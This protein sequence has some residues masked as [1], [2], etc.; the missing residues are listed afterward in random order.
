MYNKKYLAFVYFIQ[1]AVQYTAK[2]IAKSR[3]I[4]NRQEKSRLFSLEN[5]LSILVS[6]TA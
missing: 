4:K 2:E 5:Y 3:K 1:S 6:L